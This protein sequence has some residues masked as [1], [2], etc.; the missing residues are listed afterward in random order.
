MTLGGD[1]PQLTVDDLRT[2][3][4]AAQAFA[5]SMLPSEQADTGSI[6]A[7]VQRVLAVVGTGTD[8]R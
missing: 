1:P 3:A 2:L 8:A 7:A 4:F 6:E 5:M